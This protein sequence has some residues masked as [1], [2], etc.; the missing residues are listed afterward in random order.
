MY[1]GYA[2]IP[3]PTFKADQAKG[4]LLYEV[5]CMLCHMKDG[6]GKKKIEKKFT[7]YLYPPIGGMDSY[8]DGAGMNR[9]ITSA[10]F[11]QANMPFGATYDSPQVTDEKAY[12]IAAYI[13][14][15]LGRTKRIERKTIQI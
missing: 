10:R 15:F 5:K 7:G 6:S 11:I 14:T 9:V 12:H 8:N 3:I 2:K 13:N 1:K 4:Q